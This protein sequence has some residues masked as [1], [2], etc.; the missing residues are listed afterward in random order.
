MI[1]RIQFIDERQQLV[2]T[3]ERIQVHNQCLGRFVQLSR[4]V[5][6]FASQCPH[7]L[8][9]MVRSQWHMMAF[10]GGSVPV[11][12][13]ASSTVAGPAKPTGS[14]AS[15]SFGSTISTPTILG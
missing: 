15:G 7:V 8:P 4:S 1:A 13:Q 9:D 11:R 2:L 3:H 14:L 12:R 5:E 6:V 10:R